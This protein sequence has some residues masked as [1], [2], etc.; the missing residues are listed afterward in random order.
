M[1]AADLDHLR[2]WIGRSDTKRDSIALAPAAA[3]AATLD[4]DHMPAEGD[5]LPPLW[6]WLYFTPRARQSDLGTDG[7]PKLGGFMPPIPLPRR[8]WAGGR[9]EFFDPLLIGDQVERTTQIIGIESKTGQQGVLLFVTLRHRLSTQRGLAIEEEQDLVYR[10]ASSSAPPA[11][12]APKTTA[13]ASEL[14]PAAWRDALLPDPRLLFRYSALTFNTH[15]I[16]YDLAYAQDEEGYHD[17]VVQGPLTATLLAD[18]LI[19]HEGGRLRRFAFR[20]RSP[21]FA[22]ASMRLCGQ[23]EDKPGA[24]ALWAEGPD[25]KAAMTASALLETQDAD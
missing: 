10:A 23:H 5:P 8:M 22:E 20:G 7:H 2:D 24:F 4:H 17:L 15:R 12:P 6:H 16:H 3:L 1:S 9:L 19:A 21:L 13:A 14:P 25:G 18:R 11:K